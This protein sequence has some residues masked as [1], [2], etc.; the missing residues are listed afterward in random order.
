MEV[1]GISDGDLLKVVKN[2]KLTQ[3]F[4]DRNHVDRAQLE[5]VIDG[6]TLLT[7]AIKS[8]LPETFGILLD[9]GVN[10]KKQADG[11]VPLEVAV[12]FG[13]VPMVQELL[14]QDAHFTS[15]ACR[16]ASKRGD[17]YRF[18]VDLFKDIK[19]DGER[20]GKNRFNI[21]RADVDRCLEN[22]LLTAQAPREL[23]E[24]LHRGVRT[25]YRDEKGNVA[26]DYAVQQCLDQNT[27]IL[28]DQASPEPQK[29]S[30]EV[31]RAKCEADLSRK[32]NV[33]CKTVDIVVKTENR[34][35]I[36]QQL[37]NQ[38]KNKQLDK[39]FL[40]EYFTGLN[41]LNINRTF[42]ELNNEDVLALA[43]RH[44]DYGMVQLLLK[45]G[46]S[47]IQHSF[48]IALK[49]CQKKLIRLLLTHGAK[50]YRSLRPLEQII[51]FNPQAQSIIKWLAPRVSSRSRQDAFLFACLKA[52][53]GIADVLLNAGVAIDEI[54]KDGQSP[55]WNVLLSQNKSMLEWLIT[56]KVKNNLTSEQMQYMKNYFPAGYQRVVAL[57]R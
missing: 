40:K 29:K 57:R 53:V 9:A 19:L 8:Q 15:G 12:E 14:Y 45:Y 10:L 13:T 23:Q 30:V 20:D 38:I 33:C 41:S 5:H 56:H 11:T 34:E 22:M 55:L 46:A 42:I 7:R 2:G 25:N 16:L 39:H 27:K 17:M 32:T 47:N 43:V 28:L 52:D 37:I 31:A 6:E 44:C 54:A 18:F 1:K 24:L 35:W 26:V 49:K 4:I 51:Q 36:Y 3:R 21:N 48:N 50:L